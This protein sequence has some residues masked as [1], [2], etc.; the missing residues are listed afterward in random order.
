MNSTLN[1]SRRT[2]TSYCKPTPFTQVQRDVMLSGEV[3]YK[4]IDPATIEL[5]D[6]E[7]LCTE[8]V[9]NSDMPLNSVSP[10]I[11][12]DTVGQEEFVDKIIET[13]ME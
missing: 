11:L 12:G 9:V 7:I 6:R 3:V 10:V 13:N 5:P 2:H 1:A 8:N 4:D